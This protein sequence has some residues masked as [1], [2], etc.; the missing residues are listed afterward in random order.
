[1]ADRHFWTSSMGRLLSRRSTAFALAFV[2][3]LVVVAIAAPLVSPYSPTAQLDIVNL[4]ANAPSLAHPFGTDLASRDLLSRVIYGSRTSL[5]VALLAVVLSTTVGVAYGLAAGYAGGAIDGVM[6]RILD[7]LMAIPRVLLLVVLLSFRSGGSE[8]V[9]IVGIGLTGWFG[10][11]RLVRA[12]V[13]A[14]KPREYVLAAVALG[15]ASPRVVL[16]HILPNV[17]GPAV[18]SATVAIAQVIALEAGLSFIGLGARTA[19]ASWGAI[20]LDGQGAF[21]EFWWIPLFP[22]LAVV[23]TA[24]AFN[25]LGDGLRDTIAGRQVD[26]SSGPGRMSRAGA[27]A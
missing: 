11:S 1:M 4:K 12:E 13:M 20:I 21:N 24:L 8:A 26:G 17:I 15:A 2:I 10:M 14:A 22:G 6:M 9:L 3:L 5:A 25:V 19:T 18:V 27:A 23:I 7:G 16:R